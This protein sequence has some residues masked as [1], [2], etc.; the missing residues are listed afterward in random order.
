MC[1]ILW[2]LNLA[3]KLAVE[4]PGANCVQHLKAACILLLADN[5]LTS[6]WIYFQIWKQI[7]ILKLVKSNT[8][9]IVNIC[10]EDSKKKYKIQQVMKSLVFH[11]P[12]RRSECPSLLMS[13]ERDLKQLRFSYQSF[14]CFPLKTRRSSSVKSNLKWLKN[15][16]FEV[17]P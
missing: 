7:S 10:K 8:Q 11:M 16:Q 2:V 12:L 15:L 1:G 6:Q 9:I 13:S 17:L 3:I 4:I 14:I 5:R